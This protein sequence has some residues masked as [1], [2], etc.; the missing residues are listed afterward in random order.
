MFFS[1]TTSS[2]YPWRNDILFQNGVINKNIPIFKGKLL[3]KEYN[4][5]YQGVFDAIEPYKKSY[6]ILNYT[7]DTV[8][9]S[10]ND[11]P[12]VQIVPV[13][14]P[15]L[16]DVSKQSTIVDRNQAVILS[17]KALDLPN[18]KIIFNKKWPAEIPWMESDYLFVYAPKH[19]A[20][21]IQVSSGNFNLRNH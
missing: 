14:F 5:F 19:C 1:K 8:A 10:I 12:R 6:Y 13:H 11:L 17:Y 16:D 9:L 15:W 7:S 20:N 18:Y 21:D 3:T 2:Y 4:D